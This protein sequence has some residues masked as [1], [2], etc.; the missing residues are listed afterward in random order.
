MKLI[1]NWKEAP[2]FIS[3]QCMAV[4]VALQGSWEVMPIPL[5]DQLPDGV[6]TGLSITL[7][8]LGMIGRLVKQGDGDADQDKEVAG[9]AGRRGEPDS[10]DL[11]KGKK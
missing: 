8:V 7:L 6:V 1:S 4:A 5:K 3:M 2:K 9:S 11:A 10:G